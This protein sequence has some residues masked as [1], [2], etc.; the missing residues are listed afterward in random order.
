VNVTASSWLIG[1]GT[2][3]AALAMGYS[4]T[5]WLAARQGIRPARLE[6]AA[7]PPVTVLKPLCGA[8]HA[9]YECLRSFCEQD[10][11]RFEIV[12]GVSDSDDPA[13]AVVRVGLEVRHAPCALAGRSL[14]SDS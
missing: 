5:A 12:F 6:T 14:S 7:A 1:C 3:L 9:I 13:V 8:E 2:V 10:Y 11:S 4:I